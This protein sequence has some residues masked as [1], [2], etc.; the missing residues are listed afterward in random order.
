MFPA[1]P[2]SK[3]AAEDILAPHMEMLGALYPA[4]WR[5][6]EEMGENM[7]GARIQFCKR[8]RATVIYDFASMAART[9]FE[10]MGPDV[11]LHDA[12]GFLLVGFNSELYLRL[13]KFRDGTRRTSGIKTRQ[14]KLFAAQE[15]LTGMPESTNLVL[16]Y[17][18]NGD[19][20]EISSTAITCSTHGRLNWEIE[21][22]LPGQAVVMEQ[23]S[24]APDPSEPQISSTLQDREEA[25]G[26]GGR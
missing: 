23:P 2:H 14:Q 17:T 10:A 5:Q 1:M 11:T 13:K 9:N 26:I 16:G 4:A 25:E 7:P 15:P 6:W 3:D 12:Y 19:G 18:V 22:P 24:W 20:T 21:I 8:T